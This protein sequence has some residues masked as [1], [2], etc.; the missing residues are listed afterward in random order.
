MQQRS[1]HRR[2]VLRLLLVLGRQQGLECHWGKSGVYL[3]SNVFARLAYLCGT[4]K[5]QHA[6]CDLCRQMDWYARL[7]R[8]AVIVNQ[9]ST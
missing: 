8:T 7:R 5:L 3:V 4:E 2:W 1:K 9:A 6:A